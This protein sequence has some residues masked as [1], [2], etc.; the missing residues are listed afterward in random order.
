[1][2]EIYEEVKDEDFSNKPLVCVMDGAL[3]LWN[4]FKVVFKDIENKVLILDIIHV[5]EYIWTIAHIKYKEGSDE[6]KQYVYNT[7]LLMLQGKVASY[8]MELQKEMLSDGWK[9]SQREKFLKVI[10]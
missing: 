9:K 8:I 4:L 3:H 6:C 1:M 7:L 5:V 10:A 2:E